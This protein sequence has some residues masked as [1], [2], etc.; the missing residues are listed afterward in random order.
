MGFSTIAIRNTGGTDHQAFDGAGL[1]GFQFIQ[2]EI[3]YWRG[4]HT[5]TDTWERLLL[6]DLRHNA[7][8]TAW[9]VYNAAMSDEL[10]PRKPAMKF[11]ETPR[12]F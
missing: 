2:D 6:P 10:V 9:M 12:R 4:Y 11:K 5:N 3:D 7:I 8:I 1:P